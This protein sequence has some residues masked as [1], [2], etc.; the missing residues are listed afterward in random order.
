M[1]NADD[2]YLEARDAAMEAARAWTRKPGD[3]R[4]EDGIDFR[5]DREPP[6][7]LYLL[8]ID[9]RL[10]GER[11]WTGFCFRRNGRVN[12]GGARKVPLREAMAGGMSRGRAAPRSMELA[13]QLR[14]A[15]PVTRR[16]RPAMA[17]RIGCP[18][19]R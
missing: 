10:P 9:R 12:L 5:I 17:L 3:F 7:R 11:Q 4:T 18:A 2:F 6:L 1:N 15:V 13:E 8:L 19:S 16:R 14:R